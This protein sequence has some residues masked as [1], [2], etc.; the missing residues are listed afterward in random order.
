MYIVHVYNS[1]SRCGHGGCI[2][3]NDTLLVG[4]TIHASLVDVLE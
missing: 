1:S 4:P 3:H 2:S